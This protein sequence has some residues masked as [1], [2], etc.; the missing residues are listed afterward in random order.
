MNSL[1]VLVESR[2]IPPCRLRIFDKTPPILHNT[3][4]VT[5]TFFDVRDVT[6]VRVSGTIPMP[7]K[8]ERLRGCVR[9]R[10]GR[11]ARIR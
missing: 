1:S 2:N 6:H 11:V 9:E 10:D 5:F 8:G 3:P 7:L 4:R